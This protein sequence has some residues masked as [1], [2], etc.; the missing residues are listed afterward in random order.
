MENHGSPERDYG[1]YNRI[2]A[3]APSGRWLGSHPAH[4]GD[5]F[6][7]RVADYVAVCRSVVESGEGWRRVAPVR[8]DI[9]ITQ[10]CN[11]NCVF[12]F[13]RRYQNS[14]Y[15]NCA[16]SAEILQ[17]LFRSCERMG[18]KTV[19]F[20]GGGDPLVHPEIDRLLEFLSDTG[21]RTCVITNGDFLRG[22]TVE[23][24]YRHVDHLRWSVNAATQRTRQR[25]HRPFQHGNTLTESFDVIA[26]LVRRKVAA[27]RGGPII[28]ATFLL[29]DEN[30]AEAEDVARRLRDIGVDSVSFRPIY[31]DLGGVTALHARNLRELYNRLV[32]LGTT[33]FQVFVPKRGLTE[34]GS[35]LAAE[36]FDECISRRLRTVFE[37]NRDGLGLQACGVY[38]GS[39]MCNGLVIRAGQDNS[40]ESVWRRWQT[41]PRPVG[42]PRDCP[43]C[44]DVSINKT[45][46]FILGV[47]RQ[48]PAATFELGTSES[49]DA[50]ASMVQDVSQVK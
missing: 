25:L 26:D 47:L 18:V 36:H 1:C 7:E 4:D 8:V 17:E 50:I 23:L 14:Y 2:V 42:A 30:L 34:A 46:S 38:R 9:D 20:C 39:G 29:M 43:K 28:S 44:I 19:R 45:L 11:S 40:L 31:H 22:Q 41:S 10:G 48:E 24:V 16:A 15:R 27:R 3:T 35:L 49:F 21:L 6:P 12:C 37:A 13:S 33:T 5:F 32:N